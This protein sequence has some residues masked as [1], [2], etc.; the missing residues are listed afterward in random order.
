[1]GLQMPPVEEAAIGMT[2]DVGAVFLVKILHCLLEDHAQED[3]EKCRGIDTTLLDTIDD[4]GW[5]GSER[6]LLCLNAGCADLHE[7]G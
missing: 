2:A 7:V 4:E 1:M 5:D 3:G 6:S